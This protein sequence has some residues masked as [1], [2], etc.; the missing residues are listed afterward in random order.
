MNIATLKRATKALAERADTSPV[1]YMAWTP[2]QLAYLQDSSAL[3]LLRTGN[4]L[5]KTTAGLA[6][7][8]WRA[9][10]RHPH[11]ETHEPPVLIWVICVSWSQSVSIMSKFH[12][13]VPKDELD[14]SVEFAELR[15]Y[16]GKNP[17]V[18][19]KNGSIVRF[20]T[21]NQNAA[22]L[23]SETLHFAHI[24]EPVHPRTY[25][26]L[27]ARTRRTNGHIGI[28]LTPINGPTDWLRELVDE[29][30]I[31]DHHYR[32]TAENM[33]P[34]G[35]PDPLRL[36]DGTPM[37]AKWI[38][39]ISAMT[40]ESERPVV[41]HGDWEVRIEGRVFSAFDTARHVSEQM[42]GGEVRIC[43]GID[44]GDGA[45]FEQVCILIAVQETG[46]YAKVWILDEYVSQVSST[47]DMDIDG[48]VEMLRR[49]GMSWESIDYA[50]GDRVYAGKGRKGSSKSNRDLMQVLSRVLSL[51]VRSIK[52]QIRTVKRGAGHGRGSLDR[53]IRFLHHSQVRPNHFSIHPRCERTIESFLKW[54]YRR[55]SPYKHCLDGVR[56]ALDP[57]IFQKRR[58]KSNTVR[59]G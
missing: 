36:P 37:D 35:A 4:Q 1:D 28:T 46:I 15:G 8:I 53:G 6:E 29:G 34:V 44:H 12:A 57:Y 50:Y 20:R 45:S 13:L 55:D 18:L 25:Q 38:E 31:S 5:G 21:A 49:N 3:K 7:V 51:P 9:L 26:E 24:D 41:L 42:P 58:Y 16:R 54:D 40:L 17:A 39:K 2:P 10:G 43:A 48:I 47:P 22:A 23:A 11:F 19:F 32:L 52:P 27:L 14:P 33:I 56:Y 59:F 30:R